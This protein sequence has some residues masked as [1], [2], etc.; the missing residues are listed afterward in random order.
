ME[1]KMSID[2]L[3]I[4]GYD[5][6]SFSN[7]VSDPSWEY[8]DSMTGSAYPYNKAWHCRDGSYIQWSNSENHKDIR[9]EFNPN[10]CEKENVIQILNCMKY[11]SLNRVDIAFDFLEVDLS[12]YQVLD[13]KGR[14]F[15]D[16][17]SGT[18]QLETRYMGSPNSDLQVVLY[19]KAKEQ[20]IE[21]KWWRIE[22][23]LKGEW[24]KGLNKEKKNAKGLYHAFI[25]NPFEGITISLPD[26]KEYMHMEIKDKAMIEYLL[27]HP[28]AM[29]QLKR[30]TRLK[31]KKILAGLGSNKEIKIYENFNDNYSDIMY[32]IHI[33][34]EE[35][36]K[37]DVIR[38]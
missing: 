37:N 11:G 27:A 13:Q 21:G 7:C 3:V 34:T 35:S 16:W 18:C 8:I 1:P 23:R 26:E 28:E 19:D 20:G 10:K 29:G 14:S 9:F 25:E 36:R 24:L 17:Y 2:K 5:T 33:W 12:R 31:Y 4:V 32:Q 15:N 38:F 30:N 22:A 6:G